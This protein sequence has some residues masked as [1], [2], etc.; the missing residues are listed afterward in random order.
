MGLYAS[1]LPLVIYSL[2]GSSPH[3]A[4]GPAAVV[5]LLVG[6]TL[7]TEFHP[8]SVDYRGAAVVLCFLVGAL[9]FVMGVTRVGFLANFLSRPVITGFSFAAALVIALSPV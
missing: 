4:V 8:E 3:L 7:I 6:A 2:S 5:S 1:T 9:Q